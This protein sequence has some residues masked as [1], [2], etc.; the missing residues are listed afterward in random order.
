[1][2]D[3]QEKALSARKKSSDVSNFLAKVARTPAKKT[4]GEVSRLLFAMDAT[5]SRGPTWDHACH[6]QAQMFEATA[7]AGSLAVQLCHYGGFNHF[8][9]GAWCQS[10]NSLLAEMTAVNCLG[11]HTQIKR[12]LE[13][14]IAENRKNRIRAVVFVGDAIEENPDDLCNLAGQLAVLGLPLFMFQEGHDPGVRSVFK[15]MAQ[16]SGGAFAPFD[17]NS[18]SQ[19]KDLLSAVAVFATGGR[20]ALENFESKSGSPALLTR[21]LRD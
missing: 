15:Q 19:L 8:R 20:S 4:D 2:V 10:A 9:A 17:L 5:A 1:M 13:H 3:D 7:N 18:A 6:L 12:V 11:G 21:Q 14:V 16:L